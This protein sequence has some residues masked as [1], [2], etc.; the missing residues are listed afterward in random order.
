M[1]S[2]EQCKDEKEVQAFYPV[3]EEEKEEE[4]KETLTAVRGVSE[5]EVDFDNIKIE[6]VAG[7][8]TIEEIEAMH[9]RRVELID[10]TDYDPE[11]KITIF[12]GT[13]S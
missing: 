5:Y 3:Q 4:A 6:V 2:S 13:N 8:G 7:E 1:M 9:R 12:S 10:Y 11:Y